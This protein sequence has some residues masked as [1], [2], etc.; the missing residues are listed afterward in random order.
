MG[1]GRERDVKGDGEAGD[2]ASETLADDSRTNNPIS[3]SPGVA[4]GKLDQRKRTRELPGPC[5][6]LIEFEGSVI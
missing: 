1:R 3:D 2:L 6:Q 4:P 5:Y